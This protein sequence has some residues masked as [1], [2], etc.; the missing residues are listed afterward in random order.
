MATCRRIRGE[1]LV[2]DKQL[3]HLHNV[4]SEYLGFASLQ[5]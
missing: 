5:Q 1:L 3:S 4:L 2:L